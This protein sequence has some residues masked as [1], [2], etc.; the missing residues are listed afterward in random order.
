M[1]DAVDRIA[2]LQESH[3]Q[4]DEQVKEAYNTYMPDEKVAELKMRKLVIKNQIEEL[5]KQVAK[6]ESNG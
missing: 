3:R 4:L 6:D 5:K 1:R 2:F